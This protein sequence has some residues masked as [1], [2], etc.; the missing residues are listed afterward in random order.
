MAQQEWIAPPK[1]SEQPLQNAI[2]V[3]TDAGHRSQQAVVTWQENGEW[4]HKIL[5]AT[6]GDILKTLELSAVVWAFLE[7]MT[8]PLN[9]VTDS[10][11]VA[12]L[13]ARI[14][15]AQIRDIQN[16]RLFDLLWMLQSAIHQ[17]D[18][19]GGAGSWW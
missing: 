17:M 6:L 1:Y 14:E 2:T 11:Y 4:K 5:P 16:E 10:L 3:F 15:D 7:W 8:T 9:V 19:S 18:Q 13:V 12:G